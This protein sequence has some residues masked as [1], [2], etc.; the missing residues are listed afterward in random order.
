MIT[1]KHVADYVA[2]MLSVAALMLAGA[3]HSHRPPRKR[4]NLPRSSRS[5]GQRPPQSSPS[6][7]R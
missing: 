4:V 6:I 2:P 3:P 5:Q 7:P 1:L